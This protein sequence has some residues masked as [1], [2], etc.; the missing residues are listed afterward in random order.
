METHWQEEKYE[1][2]TRIINCIKMINRYI[3]FTLILGH[4]NIILIQN[5][6]DVNPQ[7]LPWGLKDPSSLV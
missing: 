5:I 2:E 1:T 4:C 7:L 3:S 6:D